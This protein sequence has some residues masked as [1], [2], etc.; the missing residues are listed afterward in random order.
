MLLP[1]R[2]ADRCHG[3]CYPISQQLGVMDPVPKEKKKEEKCDLFVYGMY[4]LV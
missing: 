2:L 4:T 3:S 1:N